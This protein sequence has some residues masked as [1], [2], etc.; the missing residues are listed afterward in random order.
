MSSVANTTVAICSF[1]GKI[2]A[3]SHGFRRR[4]SSPVQQP[5]ELIE[6]AVPFYQF[7]GTD[8]TSGN[9]LFD[10]SLPSSFCTG[11]GTALPC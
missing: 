1:D 8:W 4:V 11:E 5:A 9:E 10:V 7:L 6:K 3:N 2:L